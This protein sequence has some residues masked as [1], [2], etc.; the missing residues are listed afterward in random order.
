[1]ECFPHARHF[2]RPWCGEQWQIKLTDAFTELP[3]SHNSS[4]SWWEAL[5][6]V[7]EG[8]LSCLRSPSPSLSPGP[9]EPRVSNE[10]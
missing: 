6:W 5:P 1:M 4:Q 2:G 7:L 3:V 8:V 10:P 9:I